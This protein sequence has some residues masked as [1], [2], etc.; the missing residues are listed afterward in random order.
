MEPVFYVPLFYVKPVLYV[1]ETLSRTKWTFFM[2][3]KLY[4][5]GTSHLREE[6]LVPWGH[7]KYRFHCIQLNSAGSMT[8]YVS[9]CQTSYCEWRKCNVNAMAQLREILD[10]QM[11]LE[12]HGTATG[13]IYSATDTGN[14]SHSGI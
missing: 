10:S 11:I 13:N 2:V 9:R 7:D 8:L 6:N 5:T 14:I 1:S 4:F 3:S 12:H